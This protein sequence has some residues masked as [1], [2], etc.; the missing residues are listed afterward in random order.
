ME[1]SPQSSLTDKIVLHL[2]SIG[3][4]VTFGA[5]ANTSFLPGIDVR[6]GG[7]VVDPQAPRYP[8]DLLHEAG[9]L[10][11]ITAADRNRLDG[12]VEVANPEPVEAAA[13]AWSY[14]AAMHL[15]IDVRELFHSG[16]YR[17]RAEALAFSFEMG[18]YPGAA[19]LEN[20]GL[21]KLKRPGVQGPTYPEMLTWLAP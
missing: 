10:A 4:R 20:L 17:G 21:A 12:N 6:L 18:V 15:Q 16:G 13:I 19:A 7:L 3:L 11:V 8:A 2:R 5:V 14:A 1:D 9:H